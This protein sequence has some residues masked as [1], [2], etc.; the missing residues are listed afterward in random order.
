LPSNLWLY[1]VSGDQMTRVGAVSVTSSAVNV[2]Q[3]LRVTLKGNFAYTAV[4]PGGIEVVDLQQAISDY[5]N[6]IA[7]EPPTVCAA[8]RSD[9]Q[10]FA[11][12]AVVNT[13]PVQDDTGRNVLFLGI[14]AGDFVVPGSDPQNPATQTFVVATGSA[15]AT[16]SANPVSFVVADPNQ[17]GSSVLLYSGQLSSGSSRLTAGTAVALG[18]LTD[19]VSDA[20]GNPVVKQVAVVVGRGIAPDPANPGQTLPYVLAV[21]DLTTPS[22][23]AVLSM[24]AWPVFPTDVVLHG[25]LALIGTGVNTILLVSLVDPIHPVLAGEIDVPPGGILGDHIAVN[26][27]GLIVTSSSNSA[28]GGLH[29]ASLGAIISITGTEPAVIF[30]DKSGKV[31]KD[32][33]ITYQA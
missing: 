10:G 14:Q 25:N 8:H 30:V 23:P 29:T 7:T 28:F 19:S 31:M 11:S 15:P 2:G 17:L 24:L 33:N 21:V 16:G 22:S 3:A 1:N 5:N 27:G 4:F 20:S 13:I 12:D 26:D 6:A 32:F 9:G 18:Q